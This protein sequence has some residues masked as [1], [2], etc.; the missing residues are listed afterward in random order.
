MATEPPRMWTS[1]IERMD[2]T[3]S[4]VASR[5]RTLHIG[6]PYECAPALVS[7]ASESH[8]RERDSRTAKLRPA[9]GRDDA[10][11]FHR[12]GA[13]GLPDDHRAGWRDLRPDVALRHRERAALA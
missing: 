12:G 3:E 1:S 4:R 2:A 10:R 6:F 7:P 11:A 5:W 8:H 9:R 13:R